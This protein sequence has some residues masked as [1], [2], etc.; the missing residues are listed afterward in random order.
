[1][2]IRDFDPALAV[3]AARCLAG[4]F[5]SPVCHQPDARMR[6]GILRSLN[7][8]DVGKLCR[9]GDADCRSF[10]T[11]ESMTPDAPTYR[12]RFDVHGEL[13]V[14]CNA[15]GIIYKID[16]LRDSAPPNE[17]RRRLVQF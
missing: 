11:S 15:E 16:W 1:V 10:R 5:V 17:S 14:I 8:I 13:S 2:K 7:C 9:C 6:D 12:V 4:G 3:L